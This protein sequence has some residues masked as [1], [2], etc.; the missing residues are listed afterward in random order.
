[1]TIEQEGFVRKKH[2]A[3]FVWKYTDFAWSVE[4]GVASLDNLKNKIC[5]ARGMKENVRQTEINERG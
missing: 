1:M 3:F 2:K 5:E 4:T